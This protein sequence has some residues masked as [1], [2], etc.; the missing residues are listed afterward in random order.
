MPPTFDSVPLFLD[1]ENQATPSIILHP[2]DVPLLTDPNLRVEI[3]VEQQSRIPNH[4]IHLFKVKESK[5]PINV[6]I[7]CTSTDCQPGG[8]AAVGKGGV[9]SWKE[10]V[11][12]ECRSINS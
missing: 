7:P 4:K 8:G 10:K 1:F 12:V 11:P 3:Q 2:R 5:D 6:T 9:V